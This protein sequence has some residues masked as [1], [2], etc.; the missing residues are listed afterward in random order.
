VEHIRTRIM[1]LKDWNNFLV[2]VGSLWVSYVG[3][4][5]IRIMD[6]RDSNNF[7]MTVGELCGTFKDWNDG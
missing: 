7:L 3:H 2:I 1:D 4:I 5:R 6:L